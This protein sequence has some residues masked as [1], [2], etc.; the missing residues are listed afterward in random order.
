MADK[1]QHEWEIRKAQGFGPVKRTNIGCKH[2]PEV[3]PWVDVLRCV[4]AYCDKLDLLPDIG[5]EYEEELPRE[6][7]WGD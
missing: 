6:I 4:H 1:K 5:E 3:M 2:C 7:N